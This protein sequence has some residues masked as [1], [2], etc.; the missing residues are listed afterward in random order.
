MGFYSGLFN[1]GISNVGLHSPDLPN[2]LILSTIDVNRGDMRLNNRWIEALNVH[3]AN[4][5]VVD[6]ATI[7]TAR[8]DEALK[9]A[10]GIML[11][12]GDMNV[13]P[14]R[15]GQEP[16]S[17]RA[18]AGDGVIPKF[19]HDDRRFEASKRMIEYAKDHKVPILGVCLGLQEMNVVLGGSLRQ[20]LEGHMTPHADTDHFW[21]FPLHNIYMNR[22]G[23]LARIFGHNVMAQNSIHNVGVEIEDLAPGLRI[24]ALD[25]AWN[26]VEAFSMPG[27]PFFM[28][29]QF[30]AE[31]SRHIPENAL[32]IKEF[33]EKS[34]DHAYERP[35]AQLGSHL[36]Q[37]LILPHLN[38]QTGVLELSA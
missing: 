20:K 13:H 1:T 34:S 28:G 12:G 38:P 3:G 14:S 24:E 21:D 37:R 8:M 33:V 2:I 15:Y 27:H 19:C 7:T 18:Y 10:D 23:S 11:T 16:I 30:H 4:C 32:V 26:V 5:I 17:Q 6:P 35:C 22:A 25:G 9:I 29:I 31:S 36:G